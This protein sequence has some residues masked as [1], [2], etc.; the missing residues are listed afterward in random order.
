MS[1]LQEHIHI[2]RC[3]ISHGP[4]REL[5]PSEL[6]VIN[7]RVANSTLVHL[8][9]SRVEQPLKSGLLSRDGRHVYRVEDDIYVLLCELAIDLHAEGPG[10]NLRLRTEKKIVRDFYDKFGWKRGEGGVF[11]DLIC[12]TDRRPVIRNYI[13]KCH[14][15]IGRHL[16]KQG[17]KYL[18]D[19]ASGPIAHPEYLDFSKNFAYRVCVD[20]S[21]LALKEAK[22]KLGDQGIYIL[23]DI[24]RLPLADGVMDAAISLHTIYHVPEDEQEKAFQEVY[25]TLKTGARAVVAYTWKK[26]YLM[27]HPLKLRMDRALGTLTTL[28]AKARAKLRGGTKSGGPPTNA[29]ALYYHPRDYEWFHEHVEP[30][31]NAKLYVWSSLNTNFTITY[32]HDLLLGRLALFFIYQMEEWFPQQAGRLGQFPLFVL[33]KATNGHEPK[34][35]TRGRV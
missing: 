12:W 25:R 27:N 23:G 17:G 30:G 22:F 5:T 3:P 19:V 7:R 21:R 15:R 2:L 14:Q 18:L 31:M 35:V 8:D 10:R 28:S 16:G 9:G 26:S 24:T 13:S 20:I 33:T 4:L 6:E 11:N 29:P 34:G 1:K 32:I